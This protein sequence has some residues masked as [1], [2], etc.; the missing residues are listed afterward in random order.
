MEVDWVRVY[1][2]DNEFPTLKIVSPSDGERVPGGEPV[3]FIIE[4]DDADGEIARVVLTD[5]ARII[6]TDDTPPYE[7]VYPD[8]A[9]GC[10]ERLAVLAYDNTE[11]SARETRMLIVGEGCPQKPYGSAPA[12]IP[13]KIEAE[14]FDEGWRDE[15]YH[16]TDKANNGNQFRPDSGVDI[17]VHEGAFYVG[18]T[19]PGEWVE[20]EVEVKETGHYSLQARVSAGTTGGTFTVADTGAPGAFAVIVEPTGDWNNFVTVKSADRLP[21]EQGRRVLRV[22]YPDGAINLDWMILEKSE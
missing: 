2:T 8:L 20:Y 4:A 21:L 10:Y 22:L 15:A 11:A 9:D 7:L 1:Q 3:R 16:D 18:W 13:G 12:S 19:E 6:A 5:G 17:G 14:H